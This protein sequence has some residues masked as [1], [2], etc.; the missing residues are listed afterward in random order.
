MND[1]IERL[2]TEAAMNNAVDDDRLK[3]G[4]RC[5]RQAK[6]IIE[7]RLGEVWAGLQPYVSRHTVYDC[8]EE[9]SLQ[10]NPSNIQLDEF[11]IHCRLDTE[12][13]TLSSS[14]GNEIKLTYNAEGLGE[15]LLETRIAFYRSN[16]QVIRCNHNFTR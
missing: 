4:M 16:L 9:V 8:W 7:E 13:V 12:D 2:I 14:D 11:N 10:L 3:K 15:F 5:I 1:T 6:R